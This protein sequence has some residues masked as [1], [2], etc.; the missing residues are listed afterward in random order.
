MQENTRNLFQWGEQIIR[1]ACWKFGIDNLKQSKHFSLSSSIFLFLRFLGQ[2][3]PLE[4][5]TLQVAH[6]AQ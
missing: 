3:V 2:E 6:V 4:N 1:M 5:F